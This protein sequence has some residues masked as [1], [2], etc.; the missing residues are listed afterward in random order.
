[1]SSVE[2]AGRVGPFQFPK[3]AKAESRDQ[4][5]D[6]SHV[7]SGDYVSIAGAPGESVICGSIVWA[8]ITHIGTRDA[9][10]CSFPRVYE[11]SLM[12]WWQKMSELG[13]DGTTG[14]G[15]TTSF[16][17]PWYPVIPTNVPIFIYLFIY[18]TDILCFLIVL[19]AGFNRKGS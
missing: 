4:L 5:T 12:L 14:T 15:R 13:A 8:S 11:I 17:S 19:F 2:D 10:R 18:F 16:F 3:K 9:V 1:M 7:R 6:E